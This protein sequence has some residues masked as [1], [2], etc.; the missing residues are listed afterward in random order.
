MDNLGICPVTQ[1]GA[2]EEAL[3]SPVGALYRPLIV[4]LSIHHGHQTDPVDHF[5]PIQA[6][7]CLHGPARLLFFNHEYSGWEDLATCA[8]DLP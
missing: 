6:R 3:L 2:R 7:S 8:D 4:R 5:D 1:S